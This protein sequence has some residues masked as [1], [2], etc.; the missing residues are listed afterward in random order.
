MAV[1]GNLIDISLSSLI[2]INCNEMN[3]ARLLVKHR[4]QE[5]T[6]FF[7]EGDIVHMTLGSQEGEDVIFEL[8]TWEDGTFE[9]TKDIR[10]PKRSVESNWSHLLL[11]GLRRIDEQAL[12]KS[13]DDEDADREKQKAEHE[14]AERMAKDFTR[15]NGI[16]SALVTSKYGD[17]IGFESTKNP[18]ATAAFTAFAGRRAEE[19]GILLNAGALQ[20]ITISGDGWR[21][22]IFPSEKHLTALSMDP[23]IS[24]SATASAIQAT[25]RRHRKE[26]D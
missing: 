24:V 21:M 13:V 16:E 1:Q 19:L 23:K 17:V 3:Q 26:K 5:G 2:S 11:E 7:D 20:Q 4:D 6:L 9:L 14:A 25:K 8:L 10:A 15:I 12:M 18:K 22:T